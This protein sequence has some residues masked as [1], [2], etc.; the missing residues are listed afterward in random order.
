MEVDFEGGQ[1]VIEAKPGEGF[2]PA[3]VTR[4]VRD[5]GFGPGP[6]RLRAA[7]TLAAYEDLPAL[8]LPTA[9]GLLVLT[10]GEEL[11]ALRASRL[12]AGSRIVVEGD[13]HPPHADKPPGLTVRSWREL[14]P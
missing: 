3:R 9:P 14:E 2:D 7:G 4:A 6:L 1:A 10:G 8:S 5:A 12:P 11:D 13:L